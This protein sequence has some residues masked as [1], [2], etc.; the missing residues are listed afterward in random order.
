[1]YFSS[2]RIPSLAN[3]SLKERQAILAIA[4]Q[5]LTTPEKLIINII[6]LLVLIPAFIYLARLQHWSV[7]LLLALLW[8]SYLV[9]MRP[10]I[11]MFTQKYLTSAIKSYQQQ[12]K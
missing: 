10:I 4:E 12:I 7:P 1:M 8:L 6:K 11:L 3:Y 5:K 2:Q 9:I